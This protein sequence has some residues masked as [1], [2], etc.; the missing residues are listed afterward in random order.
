VA[1]YGAVAGIG[2]SLGL[3]LGGVIT[4]WISWRVAFFINLPIGIALTVAAVRY[5]PETRR[6]PGRL[7]VAGALASTVGMTALVYGIVRS[8]DAG[9]TD[10]VTLAALAVGIALLAFFVVNEWRAGQPIMP[11]RLFASRERTGAYAARLL[12]LGAMMGFWFFVT[13]YLQGVKGYSP[14]QAGLAFLPMTVVNFAVAVAVPRLTRRLGNGLLLAAGLAVTVIG[15]YWL[16]RLSADVAYLTGV[17]LPMILIGA[18]Q[19]ATLGPL[20]AAGI[21]GVAPQDAGA[22]S[23][24]VNVAHQLGGSLGLGIL[25]TVFAAARSTALDAPHLLAHRVA[26]SLTV[27]TGMLALALVLVVTLIM[28]VTRAAR[29]AA[30]PRTRGSTPCS[31]RASV[32]QV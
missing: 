6:R 7:D 16:S 29:V 14:L 3:L 13:Q 11:L 5:L 20:T 31:T 8:A 12:F 26:V 24:L 32:P 25:V 1:Y 9:W 19:G 28:P 21:A 4:D 22:A 2:A 17:A 18:G 15:M 30:G 23:G 27:G 10:R